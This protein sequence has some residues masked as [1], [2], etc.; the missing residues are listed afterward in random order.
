MDPGDRTQAPFSL[1]PPHP[2]VSFACALSLTGL[3]PDF[4]RP[5]GYDKDAPKLSLCSTPYTTPCVGPLI[6]RLLLPS[7]QD[8]RLPL[9]RCT[10]ATSPEFGQQQCP[11]TTTPTCWCSTQRSNSVTTTHH[12]STS[13]SFREHKAQ[14]LYCSSCLT[15][16]GT[17]VPTF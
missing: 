8:S 3:L 5:T 1:E 6:S 7:D 10:T 4:R 17:L 11:H 16:A 9:R 12:A 14:A 15:V 2:S 13:Y